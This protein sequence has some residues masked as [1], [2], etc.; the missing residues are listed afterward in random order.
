MGKYTEIIILPD[1]SK[2]DS[3]AFTYAGK[4]AGT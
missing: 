1:V 4:N 3:Y 2:F